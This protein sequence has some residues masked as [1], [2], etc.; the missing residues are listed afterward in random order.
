[1]LE[2]G[3]E[4]PLSGHWEHVHRWKQDCMQFS[5]QGRRAQGLGLGGTKMT[6]D[7][8]GEEQDHFDRLYYLSAN[9]RVVKTY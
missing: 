4:K 1:M 5:L 9:V 6:P 7:P 2:D 3:L 8:M